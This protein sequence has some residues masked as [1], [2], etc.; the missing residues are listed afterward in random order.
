MA[1]NNDIPIFNLGKSMTFTKGAELEGVFPMK[2]LI[3]LN[4]PNKPPTGVKGFSSGV[5]IKLP[6]GV[7]IFEGEFEKIHSSDNFSLLL[8]K[9]DVFTLKRGQHIYEFEFLGNSIMKISNHR[10]KE[11][12]KSS[13]TMMTHIP[14]I[15]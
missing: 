1:T 9:T 6:R 7:E 12:K 8:S 14:A 5:I 3:F 13:L 10:I 4:G 2:D 15:F 11:D